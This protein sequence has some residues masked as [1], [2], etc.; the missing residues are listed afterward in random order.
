MSVNRVLTGL[1]VGTALSLGGFNFARMGLGG[2][3]AAPGLPRRLLFLALL[4][5][6][7]FVFGCGLMMYLSIF[8]PGADA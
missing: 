6:G 1:G 4:L 2:V 3:R 5:F 8:L 7:L